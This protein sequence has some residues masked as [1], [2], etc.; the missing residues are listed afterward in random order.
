M[1]PLL[2]SPPSPRFARFA[3]SL[4]WFLELQSQSIKRTEF[5]M[6][7]EGMGIEG[8]NAPLSRHNF[9]EFLL[10]RLAEDPKACFEVREVP[11]VPLDP[12]RVNDSKILKKLLEQKERERKAAKQKPRTQSS[13]RG[14]V[15]SKGA[16]HEMKTSFVIKTWEEL[17]SIR[18]SIPNFLELHVSKIEDYDPEKAERLRKLRESQ[19]KKK[20]GKGRGK[21]PGTAPAGRDRG[22]S[23][24]GGGYD[25]GGESPRVQYR[26]SASPLTLSL[27]VAS[28]SAFDPYYVKAPALQKG[29]EEQDTLEV[30]EGVVMKQQ[31]RAK[32]LG[33][34]ERS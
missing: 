1:P 5:Q 10:I 3:R 17:E 31:V 7:V 6:I 23:G 4:Q 30:K 13:W 12:N 33:A 11:K 28:A 34:T 24:G 2:T 15:R 14:S 22:E 27:V 20:K 9:V 8:A 25:D 26:T 16:G 21:R 29:I 32:K 19:G 18:A